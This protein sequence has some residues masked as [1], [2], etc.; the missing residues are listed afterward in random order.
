MQL[1]VKN[2]QVVMV[3]QNSGVQV[4]S[5]PALQGV[6]PDK[7]FDLFILGSSN[8]CFCKYLKPC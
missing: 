8:W 4:G 5:W 2:L 7:E 6:L 1:G 3:V